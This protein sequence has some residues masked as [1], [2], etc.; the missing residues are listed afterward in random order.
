M[1]VISLISL[2]VEAAA[3][4]APGAAPHSL[5]ECSDTHCGFSVHPFTAP[6]SFPLFYYAAPG[7]INFVYTYYT[8][9]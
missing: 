1:P 2:S 9:L 3:K 6:K 7:Y 8:T 5:T 4:P